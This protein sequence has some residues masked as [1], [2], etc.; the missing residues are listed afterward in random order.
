MFYG[1]IFHK[2]RSGC[3]SRMLPCSFSAMFTDIIVNGKPA[4]F[5]NHFQP[6]RDLSFYCVCTGWVLTEQRIGDGLKLFECQPIIATSI[7]VCWHI[8][9]P[10][11]G[12]MPE[13]HASTPQS[14]FPAPSHWSQ[15]TIA[16]NPG[17]QIPFP[18]PQPDSAFR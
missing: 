14:P 2:L 1:S 3:C 7:C 18:E 8:L 6:S 4:T 10:L 12:L 5:D 11:I 13:R 17:H 9:V 15:R 16:C